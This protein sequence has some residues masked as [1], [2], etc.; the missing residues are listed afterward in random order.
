MIVPGYLS[1]DAVRLQLGGGRNK[2]HRKL[3]GPLGNARASINAVSCTGAV[4]G[5]QRSPDWPREAPIGSERP[6]G[7]P[8]FFTEAERSPERPRDAQGGPEKPKEDQRGPQRPRETQRDPERLRGLTDSRVHF[9]QVTDKSLQVNKDRTIGNASISCLHPAP[10]K[11]NV[12]WK[13]APVFW[14]CSRTKVCK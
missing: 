14:G 1:E 13:S 3:S 8:D 7:D 11:F 6:Q 4:H 10:P 2:P 12:A 9:G 5:A